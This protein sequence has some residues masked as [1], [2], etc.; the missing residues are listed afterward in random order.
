M[1]P[2]DVSQRQ[3]E[4]LGVRKEEGFLCAAAGGGSKVCVCVCT[5]SSYILFFKKKKKK[6][7]CISFPHLCESSANVEVTR[8]QRHSVHSHLEVS[9]YYALLMAILHR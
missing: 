3:R 9:V 2:T 4:T 1:A 6:G 7:V 5:F 8:V